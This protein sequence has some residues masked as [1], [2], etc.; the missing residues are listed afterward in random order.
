MLSK[1]A[2]TLC[3]WQ[4]ILADITVV[5]APPIVFI[6]RSPPLPLLHLNQHQSDTTVTIFKWTRKLVQSAVHLQTSDLLSLLI[7]YLDSFSF[8]CSVWWNMSPGIISY[9]F[10]LW[11]NISTSS[12]APHTLLVL[13]WLL[14]VPLL[15]ANSFEQ[16]MKD[17]TIWRLR[18][19]TG[20]SRHKNTRNVTSECIYS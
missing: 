15:S 6:K 7:Q 5:T 1:L 18:L 8:S 9:S 19:V 3:I 11:W 12:S 4:K 13:K 14:I 20:W 16:N 17:Y 2:I 10:S